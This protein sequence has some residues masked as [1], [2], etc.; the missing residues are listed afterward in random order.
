MDAI[1]I[2]GPTAS[3]KSALGLLVAEQTGGEIVS[4]D[5]RQ[6]YRG[7]DIGT[8]KPS[9]AERERI[10]HHMLDILDI[11]QR[12]NAAWFAQRAREETAAI[13]ARGSLPILVGGSG[14]YLRAVLQGLFSVE[15]D[16]ARRGM[17]EAEVKDIPTS[18]LYLRLASVD[19]QSQARIHRNDRYRIVRAL[20]I[21]ALTGLPLSLHFERQAS[22][23]EGLGMRCAVF[24]ILVP[25]GVLRSRIIERTEY[26]YEA[27]WPAEVQGLLAGG[28]D[29]DWPGMKTLG[30]PEMVAHVRGRLDRE[31]VIGLI[32]LRTAQYAKRQMTWFRK[33]EVLN[34]MD[35]ARDDPV[36]RILKVLDTSEAG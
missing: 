22:P 6:A 21:Q 33:V 14:L 25:R 4:I 9:P 7:L 26:M 17:F 3:G 1:V 29:P 13:R 35:P 15:I 20:E 30:Y 5:S 8:A 12:G 28:A 19:P 10:P 34:W 32:A 2:V 31:R 36:G 23:G 24:G 18:D 16:L 27:G 11:N